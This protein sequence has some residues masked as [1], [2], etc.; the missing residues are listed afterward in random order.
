MSSNHPVA[1]FEVTSPD[2]PRAQAFYRDL[3]GWSIEVDDEGYGLVDTGAGEDGVSGGIG[4]AEAPEQAGVTVYVRTPDLEG[5]LARA[6]DLGSTVHLE[7]MELPGGYGR[8]AV[9]GDPD[10]NPVGLW[11]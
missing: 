4:P 10:G 5:T 1:F 2:A 3:F 8:I 6:R 7:P 11:A 9:V